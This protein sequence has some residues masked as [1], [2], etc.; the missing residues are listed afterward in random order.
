M[1]H[2]QGSGQPGADPPTRTPIKHLVVIFQENRTFDHYF[3]TY[4][5][6]ANIDGEQSWIGV[7]APEFHARQDTPKANNYL[8]NRDVFLHNPNRSLTGGQANPQR[9]RPADAWT[10]TLN[11]NGYTASEEAVDGGRMDQFVQV[12]GN[13]GEGCP[14]GGTGVM[15]YFDGN[16]V[17]YLW[18]YAQHYAMSDAFFQTN[19]GPSLPGHINLVSGNIHGAV[20]QGPP[21][22]G[23]V[24]TSPVDGSLTLISNADAVLDDC[25]SAS[26]RVEMTG[27]N[28]GDLLN[29]KNITWG[30]FQGGFAPTQ[31]AV[32]NADG[33]TQTPA[34]CGQGHM[35]SEFTIGDKTFLVPNPTINFTTD[36]H[37]PVGD[38][39]TSTAPFMFYASTRNPHHLPPSSAEAIGKSTDQANH[40]Y[41]TLDFLAAIKAGNLPAVTFLKAPAYANDHPGRDPSLVGQA[42]VVQ[43]VNEIVKLSE[44]ESTAII[45]TFDDA[46][47]WYDHVAPP[48]LDPSN[49]AIDVQC[50]NGM[51]VP[52]DQ[53]ARCRLGLRMPFLVISPWAKVNYIGHTVTELA[54]VTRFIEDNWDLGFIDGPVAPPVGTG[55]FD[56]VAGSIEGMFDFG[57]KPNVRPL[58]LDPIRGT[59]VV[60]NQ[61]GGH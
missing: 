6:A 33:S 30:W 31:P 39:T 29:A 35:A 45:I 20:V 55:S 61:D 23:I 41:D 3:G 37:F 28:V 19:Y 22:A 1:G 4:P 24:F 11:S 49:T 5:Q 2:A 38:Y 14:P 53:F 7:T 12:L 57:Q 27:R 56:R 16:T 15:N 8:T 44:W 43:M 9:W 48:V 34:V 52:G 13:S 54:S 60:D 18:N 10:C 59:V 17:T 32:L 42:W 36:I 58:L 40:Q 50:G 51:P 25:G 47:T 21:E 26:T 46:G